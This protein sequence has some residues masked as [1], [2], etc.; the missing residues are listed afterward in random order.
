MFAHGSITDFCYCE[1]VGS[2]L[3]IPSDARAS[4]A[5][6]VTKYELGWERITNVV[7]LKEANFVSFCSHS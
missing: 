4:R 6:H 2:I 5:G 7:V 3:K 1:M